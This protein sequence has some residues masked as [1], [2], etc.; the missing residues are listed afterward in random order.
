[1]KL[2]QSFFPALLS[3]LAGFTLLI[4]PSVFA[5]PKADCVTPIN[6]NTS[7]VHCLMTVHGIGETMADRIVNYRHDHGPF[8]TM[9]A[10][11]AVKGISDKK[12]VK[13]QNELTVVRTDE[14]EK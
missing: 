14:I 5:A 2:P 9:D 6:V 8:K 4:S 10:L 7:D 12:L 1:M 13:W 3:G 11:K